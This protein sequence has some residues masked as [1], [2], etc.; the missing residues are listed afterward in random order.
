V[1]EEN[2][3]E[4]AYLNAWRFRK[5]APQLGHSMVGDSAPDGE[6]VQLEIDVSL[7]RSS[8]VLGSSVASI[9]GFVASPEVDSWSK[10]SGSTR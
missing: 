4:N 2:E 5:V 9:V 8:L 3:N 1:C 10:G 6:V 7:D